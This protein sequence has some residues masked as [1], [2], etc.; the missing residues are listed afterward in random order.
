M[1][2]WTYQPL[3]SGSRADRFLGRFR[4]PDNMGANHGHLHRRSE[5]LPH[6]SPRGCLVSRRRHGSVLYR[7]IL[8]NYKIVFSKNNYDS[9]KHNFSNE[10]SKYVKHLPPGLPKPAPASNRIDPH[11]QA[12]WRGLGSAHTTRDSVADS[13]FRTDTDCRP[14]GFSRN[15]WGAPTTCSE[16]GSEAMVRSWP[17]M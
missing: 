12:T 13:P 8:Y 10:L 3:A 2:L 17:L 4:Q 5:E 1:H 9:M 15:T 16:I 7:D 11:S 6:S 14:T